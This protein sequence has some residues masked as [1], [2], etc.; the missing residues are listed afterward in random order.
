ML[1]FLMVLFV[2]ALSITPETKGDAVADRAIVTAIMEA[3][4]SVSFECATCGEWYITDPGDPNS[5]VSRNCIGN[6]MP[7]DVF[8]Q[9]KACMYCPDPPIIC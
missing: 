7:P 4:N 2:V 8:T 3:E 9:S 1:F 5:T 6:Y